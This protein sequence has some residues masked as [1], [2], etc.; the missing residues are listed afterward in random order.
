MDDREFL[1]SELKRLNARIDEA[2]AR[3]GAHSVKPVLMQALFELEE[4]RDA[5]LQQLKARF[6]GGGI[7]GS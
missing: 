5:I 3:L 4:E 7:A 2:E 6:D 1:N